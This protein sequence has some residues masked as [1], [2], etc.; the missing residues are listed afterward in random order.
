DDAV[1]KIGVD[2]AK[3]RL[4]QCGLLL[5]VFD[6]SRALGDFDFQ[7]LETAKTVPSLAIINKTDLPSQLDINK[8]KSYIDN[9]IFISAATGEGK[10]ELIQAIASLAGTDALNPSEGILSNERQ[11]ANVSAALQSVREAKAAIETGMTFDA[12]TVSLEDAISELLEMTGERTSDEVIDR[13]FHNFC[14]GK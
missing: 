11:R 9:I 14:V 12:V 7:L 1:E 5:A 8:I 6:N 4:E 10:E 2:R 3:Q 13:V